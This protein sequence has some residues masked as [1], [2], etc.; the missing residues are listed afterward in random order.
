MTT[1]RPVSPHRRSEQVGLTTT[2]GRAPDLTS[3]TGT[4]PGPGSEQIGL[5]T[6]GGRAPDLISWAA[7]GDEA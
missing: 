3:W 6:T 5:A 7:K 2:G 4:T 1:P